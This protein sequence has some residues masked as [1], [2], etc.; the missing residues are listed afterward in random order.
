MI[1]SRFEALG[2]LPSKGPFT[3]W[4]YWMT[5]SGWLASSTRRLEEVALVEFLDSCPAFELYY[6]TVKKEG[7]A[8]RALGPVVDCGGGWAFL[9]IAPR[10]GRRSVKGHNLEL[11]MME[12]SEIELRKMLLERA[13]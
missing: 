6:L 9:K 3:L 1:I 5:G 4:R 11:E 7:K 13:A 8:A 2:L 12:L 10:K